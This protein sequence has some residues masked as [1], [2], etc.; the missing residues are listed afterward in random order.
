M[1]TREYTHWAILHC[2]RNMY[3]LEYI[4]FDFTVLNSKYFNP[5]QTVPDI[6]Q[7]LQQRVQTGL[8]DPTGG[9]VCRPVDVIKT[10]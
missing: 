7:V 4:G 8:T 5:Q 1:S 9:D 6:K 2:T 10:V 3:E